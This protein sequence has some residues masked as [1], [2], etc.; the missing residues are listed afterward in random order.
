MVAPMDCPMTSGAGWEEDAQ[1]TISD[2]TAGD[3]HHDE[4]KQACSACYRLSWPVPFH[5]FF[6]GF[7]PPKKATFLW[8]RWGCHLSLSGRLR[9]VIQDLPRFEA[10]PR[11]LPPADVLNT[12][13][14]SGVRGGPS[15]AAGVLRHE[16]SRRVCRSM[17]PE[18]GPEDRFIASRGR[19]YSGLRFVARSGSERTAFGV[20]KGWRP[21]AALE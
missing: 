2:T 8:W 21:P 12:S 6:D 11:L 14:D 1:I 3:R 19:G 18:L 16:G 5:G 10:F 15:S 13:S 9:I 20:L 17:S 7:K 4:G